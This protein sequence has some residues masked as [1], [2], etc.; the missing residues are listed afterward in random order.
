MGSGEVVILGG[1]NISHSL[2]K[3]K[4]RELRLMDQNW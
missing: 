1:E 2:C 3:Q 4:E